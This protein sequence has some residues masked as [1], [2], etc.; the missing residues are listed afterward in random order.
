VQAWAAGAYYRVSGQTEPAW[1]V[2]PQVLPCREHD[3]RVGAADA[4]R[5]IGEPALEMLKTC[6]AH[7][8]RA[9]APA[10]ELKKPEAS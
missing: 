6:L 3:V 5:A 4:A 9:I 8:T 10:P 2:L 7:P 1:R